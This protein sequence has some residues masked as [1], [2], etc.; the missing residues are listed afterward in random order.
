MWLPGDGKRRSPLSA[1]QLE[2]ERRRA[3]RISSLAKDLGEALGVRRALA[4][5]I[6]DQPGT[7]LIA[8]KA[9]E[10]VPVVGDHQAIAKP[11]EM[12][13]RVDDRQE[14]RVKGQQVHQ[15]RAVLAGKIAFAN[16]DAQLPVVTGCGEQRTQGSNP[17]R[18]F[19][20][21]G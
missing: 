13:R 6:D 16:D 5:I 8:M 14:R 9:D 11:V 12:G 1:A 18:S 15:V 4:G 19:K 10:G 7:R 17:R 20:P 21:Q 2:S 3:Q